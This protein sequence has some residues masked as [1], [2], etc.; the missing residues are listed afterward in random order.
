M[1]DD[2]VDPYS[3]AAN[4]GTLLD[5]VA[6][7]ER[8]GHRRL[9]A[10]ADIVHMGEDARIDDRTAA[11]LD[12]MM[13][14]T[15][16]AV[17]AGVRDH[18]AR[19]LLSRGEPGLAQAIRG[20][21]DVFARLHRAGLFRDPSLFAELFARVRLATIAQALPVGLHDG[22]ER[23]TMLARL[24]QAGDRLVAAAALALLT[25]DARRE[26]GD[27][28]DLPRPQ[29]ARVAWWV[30][31]ALRQEA[32][33]VAADRI[34]AVDAALTDAVRRSFDPQGDVV[35]V[36]VAAM[37]LAHAIDAQ[38][39]ELPP[40]IEE[41][42][43]DGRLI[44]FVALVARAAGL[45]FDRMRDLVIDIDGARL[46]VVLR[47]LGLSRT[48]IARIG[49]ALAEAEPA[50]D[51]ERFADDLDG[52]MALDPAAARTALSPMALDPDYHAALLALGAPR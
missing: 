51:V 1:S 2:P 16:A 26:A 29:H 9:R 21:G 3:A 8:A 30:A 40:L 37:R 25:A 43:G 19:L 50:R 4:A 32:A 39:G 38:P 11:L 6:A 15:I 14:A 10:A 27:G 12:G 24:A 41:A 49:F 18:A 42:I 13:R 46:W 47:S 52:I 7:A 5:H 20:A 35:P 17:T 28:V 48:T 34:A 22:P 23:P 45:S 31:A 36:E 33:I 44:L